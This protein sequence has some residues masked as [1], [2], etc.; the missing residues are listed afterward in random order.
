MTLDTWTMVISYDETYTYKALENIKCWRLFGG[1]TESMCIALWLYI[2]VDVLCPS[3][4]Y[5][6]HAGYVAS[7]SAGLLPTL[8]WNDISSPTAQRTATVKEWSN[9]NQFS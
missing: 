6:D 2:S 9:S 3:Q 8:R 4:H 1:I 7:D 5:L